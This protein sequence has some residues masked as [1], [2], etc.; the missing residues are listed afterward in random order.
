MIKVTFGYT[1]LKVDCISM[2]HWYAICNLSP[3]WKDFGQANWM[4]VKN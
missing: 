3:I 1:W 2:W 4:I